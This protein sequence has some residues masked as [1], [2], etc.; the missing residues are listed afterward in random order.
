MDNQFLTY[1]SISNMF[2]YE[3]SRPI[4]STGTGITQGELTCFY[5]NVTGGTQLIEKK[6]HCVVKRQAACI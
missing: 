1:S 3:F 5:A 4:K 6:T 2:F